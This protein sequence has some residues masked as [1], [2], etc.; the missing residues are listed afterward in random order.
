MNANTAAVSAQTPNPQH[1][2]HAEQLAEFM[3]AKCHWTGGCDKYSK[4]LQGTIVYQITQKVWTRGNFL[5][6]D[7]MVVNLKDQV[8]KRYVEWKYSPL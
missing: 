3:S 8:A 5:G 4:K 6:V 7:F 1:V 2:Q